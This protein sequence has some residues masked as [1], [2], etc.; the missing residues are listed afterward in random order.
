MWCYI[1]GMLVLLLVHKSHPDVLGS[2]SVCL[3]TWHHCTVNAAGVPLLICKASHCSAAHRAMAEQDP[4][5]GTGRVYLTAHSTC[6]K[7]RSHLQSGELGRTQVQQGC[8]KLTSASAQREQ[9][10]PAVHVQHAQTAAAHGDAH[11]LQVQVVEFCQ[12]RAGRICAWEASKRKGAA[13]CSACHTKQASMAWMARVQQPSENVLSTL[14]ASLWHKN[15]H[16]ARL[17]GP[18]AAHMRHMA[19]RQQGDAGQ[20]EHAPGG[21]VSRRCSL[22]P[23]QTEKPKKCAIAQ[24]SCADTSENALLPASMQMVS[25]T[26]HPASLTLKGTTYVSSCRERAPPPK[27]FCPYIHVGVVA[28]PSAEREGGCA[29]C[30]DVGSHHRA[31]REPSH[32]CS[33]E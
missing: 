11:L 28:N 15:M 32:M 5:T 7:Q 1:A 17:Q 14:P 4:F 12:V 2:T 30:P 9:L 21:G 18:L 10:L 8:P 24:A 33:S 3:P 25:R 22:C 16:M 31:P 13:L 27:L 20:G 29:C 19:F 6:T 26:E 23:L